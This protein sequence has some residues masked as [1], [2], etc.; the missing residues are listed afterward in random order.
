MRIAAQLTKLI[1]PAMTALLLLNACEERYSWTE[2]HD[3]PGCTGPCYKRMPCEGTE[4]KVEIPI[5]DRNLLRGENDYKFYFRDHE[6]N[7][8]IV[9]E[10]TENIPM[11]ALDEIQQSPGKTLYIKGVITGIDIIGRDYCQRIPKVVVQKSGD[12]YLR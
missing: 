12:F 1:L 5:L 6:T 9:V 7:R 3:I 2:L 8:S 4:V 11:E 10:F